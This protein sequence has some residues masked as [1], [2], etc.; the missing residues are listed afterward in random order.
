MIELPVG[1][2]LATIGILS[3]TIATISGIMWTFMQSRLSAQDKIIN[4]QTITIDKLQEDIQRLA[5]GCGHPDCH[6]K[7]RG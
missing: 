1:W 4:S 5:K 6:W 7:H 3:T 2:I